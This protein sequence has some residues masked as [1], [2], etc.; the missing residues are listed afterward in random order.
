MSTILSS[1]IAKLL[2]P[3]TFIAAAAL[4][5]KGYTSVGDGFSAG[6]TAASG[7]L[8]QYLA[9]KPQ[10]VEELTPVRYSI[11]IAM[12]GLLLAFV[13]VFWPALFGLP[14]LTHFPRPAETVTTWGTLEFH[15]AILFDLGV[16]G[17]VFGF[18]VTTMR[19]LMRVEQEGQR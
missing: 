8:L 6:V 13:V 18:I 7:I 12:A 10:V 4:L 15:T 19:A 14:I 17:L 2:L 3:V 11:N 16:F 9:F 5:V 1:G